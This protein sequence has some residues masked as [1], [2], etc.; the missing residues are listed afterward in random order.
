MSENKKQLPMKE[1]IAKVLSMRG[2]DGTTYNAVAMQ[3]LN[4]NLAVEEDG[5]PFTRQQHPLDEYYYQRGLISADQYRAGIGFLRD[6]AVAFEHKSIVERLMKIGMGVAAVEDRLT[7]KDRYTRVKVCLSPKSRWLVDL[8]IIQG[9]MLKEIKEKMKWTAGN[10]GVDRFCEALDEV[11]EFYHRLQQ[12][13]NILTREIKPE[14]EIILATA[15]ITSY[16]AQ[17]NQISV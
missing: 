3:V 7:A 9:F 15:L 11:G 5:R 2:V 4:G 10:T 16:N 17:H 14:D 8:V 1:Y 6:Y 13:E 12:G